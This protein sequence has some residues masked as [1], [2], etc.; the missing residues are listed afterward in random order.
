MTPC[1]LVLLL[2]AEI[3]PAAS[4][5]RYDLAPGDHLV[6][7]ETLVQDVTWPEHERGVRA[8]WRAHVVVKGRTATGR[9]AVGIARVRTEA[10]LT[11]YRERGQD[12]LA[13]EQ[14]EFAQRLSAW[15]ERY[16]EA[17]VVDARGTPE[18]PWNAVREWWSQALFDAHEI[19][20]LPATLD[21][22]AP[23]GSALG[24]TV[25]QA[26]W[27]ETTAG[28]IW[29]VEARDGG[30]V[31]LN[32]DFSPAAGV[33][34]HLELD[35]GYGA[36]PS[37]IVHERWTVD[38]VERR[39][40]EDASLWA[41]DTE[42]ALAAER[43]AAAL[44]IANAPATAAR[45]PFLPGTPFLPIREGRFA[46]HPYIVSVPETYRTGRPVPLLVYLSGGPGQ[47]FSGALSAGRGEVDA[48]WLVVYPQ[49]ISNWWED[50]SVA[51]LDVLFDELLARFD[52]DPDRVYLAGASNGGTGALRYAT[53][54]PQRFAAVV[55]WMGA[56]RRV[57]PANDPPLVANLAH[58]PVLFVHGDRDSVVDVDC[59]KDAVAELRRRAPAAPVEL[60]V[61]KG[62]GHDIHAGSDGDLGLPFLARARR[63]PFPR[64][65]QL[66]LDDLRHPR[67][68]WVEVAE[69]E[70]GAAEVTA[71][72]GDDNRLDLRCRGVRRL[73][74]HL[75][76]E[77]FPEAGPVRV[78]ANGREVYAGA[79][80]VVEVAVKAR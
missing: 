12:R 53:F 67:R 79:P 73:R 76:P 38:L 60:H 58:L 62:R 32:Y 6:F 42:T 68:Y 66:H 9:A 40:G 25:R 61:L 7:R 65:V 75:V 21:V 10:A 71:A 78:V 1:C 5:L 52:V 16:V 56:G 69:K 36:A 23:F 44:A 24:L 63:D 2:A 26:R 49:A 11:R 57:F 35:A 31:R 33:V 3:L 28:T 20:A 15:P 70:G 48:D 77:L 13:Q 50:D 55:S 80:S 64:Q 54:S 59:S 46:G 18:L 41:A 19:A 4:A 22:P 14:P 51:M 8:A 39:R 37:S 17:N 45:V 34:T 47:A 30:D 74:L 43:A 72:I 29:R 27:V